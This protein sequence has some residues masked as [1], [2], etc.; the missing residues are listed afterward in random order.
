[1]KPVSPQ[2]PS[3]TSVE[4]TANRRRNPRFLSFLL[5]YFLLAVALASAFADI[6]TL[7][8]PTPTRSDWVDVTKSPYFADKTGATDTTTAIQN[9]LNTITSGKTIYFP[10][11][12]YKIT[13]TLNIPTGRYT[14]ISL[15]GHGAATVLAWYGT[16]GGTLLNNPG[17]PHSLFIGLKLDGRGIA[18]IGFD[19]NDTAFDTGA[20]WKHM[21]FL[22]FTGVGV[23]TNASAAAAAAEASFE[24]CIFNNCGTGVKITKFNDYDFTITGSDFINCGYGVWNNHGNYYV[25]N[26]YFQ[27]STIADV[28]SRSPEHGCSIRRSVSKNSVRF[29]DSDSGV[30]PLFVEDCYVSGWTST[31]GALLH[32]PGALTISNTTFVNPPDTAAPLRF[33][34]SG[35]T[36]VTS[37]NNTAPQSSSLFPSSG[38]FTVY[39]VPAGSVPGNISANGANITSFVNP[40][41]SV[42]AVVYDAK[43]YGAVGNGTTDDTAA[44]QMVI[45]KARSD[46]NGA[47]AY[48]PTGI[49]KITSALN[50][51]GSD[52]I[53]GGSGYNARLFWAGAAGG[54]IISITDPKN[55][56]LESLMVGHHDVSGASGGTNAVDIA[57]TSTGPSSMTYSG[58][59]VYGNGRKNPSKQGL[60]LSNL[61]PDNV[62]NLNLLQGNTRIINS[63]RAT[64][65]GTITYEGAIT[66]DD[67][68]STTRDGFLGFL[69]RLSTLNYESLLVNN[70]NSIVFSD[71]YTEQGQCGPTLS[72]TAGNPSGRITLCSPK[73]QYSTVDGFSPKFLTVNDYQGD[74]F[75]LSSQFDISPA[76]MPVTT[77]GT[78]H[79]DVVLFGNPFYNT[80]LS[81]PSS[82][83]DTLYA[84]GNSAAGSGTAPTNNYN[85]GTLTK[86]ALAFDD[87][88]KL[89]N[90]DLM[91]N[92]PHLSQ[93]IYY[94]FN[95]ASGTTTADSSGHGNTGNLINGPV[96][97]TGIQGNSLLFNGTSTYVASSSATALPAANAR[98]TISWWQKANASGEMV[99]ACLRN[100]TTNSGVAVGRQSSGVFGAWKLEDWSTL[101]TVAAAPSLNVWHHCAYTFDG[102]THRL[103]I[104]GAQVASSTVTPGTSSPTLLQVGSRGGWTNASNFSGKLDEL[105]VYQRALSAAEIQVLADFTPSIAMPVFSADFNGTGSGTGGATDVVSIGG[106][107]AVGASAGSTYTI[108]S[109]PAMGQANYLNVA[110]AA[111]G[112]TTQQSIATFTP[113]TAGSWK[114]LTGTTTLSG[115]AYTTLN[116]AFDIFV[117][118]NASA[119]G[120]QSWFRPVDVDG[121]SGNAGLRIILTGVG[122]SLQFQLSSN[123]TSPY[124]F[125]TGGTWNASTVVMTPGYTLATGTAYHIAVTLNTDPLTGLVTAKLFAVSGGAAIDT[126]SGTNLLASTSFYANASVIGSNALSG[127]AW[128]M[129]SRSLANWVATNV[130]YDAI[131]IYNADPKYLPALTSD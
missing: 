3:I 74:I 7:N 53:V 35:S 13:Q 99:A 104:D 16:A 27:G 128:T 126:T 72:G 30:S 54:T 29:V 117:R 71:Y 78:R 20:R 10:A 1:M 77:S 118:R 73:L 106:T 98:Q 64:I 49:Y 92:L 2:T 15:V 23:Q 75:V 37:C 34:S 47:I 45:D 112:N 82:G 24:N 86:A 42:P 25:R 107:G 46:G 61:G 89:G 94:K 80:S 97:T 11:G 131:R 95:E 22:N 111:A 124:A 62:V 110:T 105:R 26:C 32:S 101:A 122:N 57:Q 60:L 87:L 5:V 127:G 109:S 88:Q 38:T 56:T 100:S 125:S 102:T 52:Y 129:L 39:T 66:V 21:A 116:G 58:V 68:T 12:T 84:F 44:I 114:S 63:A 8:W 103:Y 40:N 90:L 123:S 59:W 115:V 14:G 55:L 65:L 43:A 9:A 113:T 121:R 41:V 31:G 4:I 33:V 51:T 18:A 69:T 19:N 50:V 79:A 119:S 17:C 36:S 83:P 93:S 70:N 81:F 85:S 120:D 108:K 130:D 48:I 96:W 28:Y 76:P 91:M 67:S 6:P